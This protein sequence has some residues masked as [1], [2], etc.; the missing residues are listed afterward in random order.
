M[1]LSPIQLLE[2]HPEKVWIERVSVDLGSAEDESTSGQVDI[3]FYKKMVPFS[4]FW[5]IEPAVPGLKDRT[6]HLTLGVRTPENLRAGTYVFEIVLTGV[7]ACIPE[8]VG[9]RIPED[10]VFEY[11]L[12]MLYGMVREQLVA[13]SSRMQPGLQLLPTLSFMGEWKAEK[14]EL[15]K[16]ETDS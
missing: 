3:Q 4:D 12:T 1:K 10:V 5:K 14:K 8:K 2:S 11:G 13:I 7:F 9:N 16:L 15:S 6:F